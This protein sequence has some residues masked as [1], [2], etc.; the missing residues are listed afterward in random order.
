MLDVLKAL[1]IDGDKNLRRSLEYNLHLEG[2]RVYQAATGPEGLR[3]AQNEDIDVILMD[4]ALP[5]MD[6]LETLAE[7]KYNEKTVDIAVFMLSEHGNFHDLER[8][9]E[10]GALDYI[11]KPF[12]VEEIGKMIRRKLEKTTK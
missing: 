4:M 9:L 11:S 12:D 7:L 3:V 8:A 10:I 5:N 2:F 1:V 6:G